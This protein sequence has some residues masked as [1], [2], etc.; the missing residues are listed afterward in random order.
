VN[1]INQIANYALLEYPD[2]ANISDQSPA[3]YWPN[4]KARYSDDEWQTANY[5]HA[6]PPAW[7][8]MTYLDFL[9]ERRNRIAQVIRDGFEK[10]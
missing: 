5:W 1:Q 4:F 9:A 3:D 6:L 8:E 10:I 2:N 7:S